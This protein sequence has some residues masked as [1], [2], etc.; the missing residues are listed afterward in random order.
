MTD[1]IH[2]ILSYSKLHNSPWTFLSMSSLELH[3]IPQRQEEE[4]YFSPFDLWGNRS[5]EEELLQ[6]TQ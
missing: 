3:N 4:D 2:L 5:M 1:N 6:I